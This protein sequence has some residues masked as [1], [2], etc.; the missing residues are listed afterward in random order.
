MQ[1]KRILARDTKAAQQRACALYGR[2]VMIISNHSVDGQCELVVAVDDDPVLHA[3]RVASAERNTEAPAGQG[4]AAHM[5]AVQLTAH[6]AS[7]LSKADKSKK[8]DPGSSKLAS[9]HNDTDARDYLR[10]REL[11]DMVRE[12]ISSIRREFAMSQ[13]ISGWQ[14]GLN[15]SDAIQTTMDRFTEAGMSAGMRTLLLDSVQH[16]QT[17]SEALTVINQQL[18]QSLTR[19]SVALPSQGVHLL[20]GNSGSGKTL[21]AGRIARAVA[22]EAG[23]EHV[24]LISYQ[25]MRVGAWNQIQMLAAQAGVD[26][27]RADDLESLAAVLQQFASRRLILIDTSGTQMAQ[28]IA[29]VQSV[30]SQL[31]VHAV[32][33]AD[34]SNASLARTLRFTQAPFASMMI[35]KL[36][37]SMQPW[38]LVEFLCHSPLGLSAVSNGLQLAHVRTDFEAME[39]VTMALAQI[40]TSVDAPSQVKPLASI[41]IKGAS[42]GHAAGMFSQVGIHRP[43]VSIN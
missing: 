13:K 24:L 1:L 20:A 39:L 15:V 27:L 34:A 14:S 18:S 4:F 26:C 19:P 42:N 9:A 10:G 6:T 17:E 25:D 2:D 29:E 35:S 12:E 5:D 37:E 22:K 43:V 7:K 36:D 21:M 8:A 40:D 31:T 28:R 3:A 33:T 38:P 30:C 23:A 16:L 41:A 11:V 32:V